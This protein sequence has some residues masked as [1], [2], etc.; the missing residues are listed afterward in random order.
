MQDDVLE[1][2]EDGSFDIAPS[3][4]VEQ[5]PIDTAPKDSP[6]SDDAQKDSEEDDS[7]PRKPKEHPRKMYSNF[8]IHPAPGNGGRTDKYVWAQTLSELTVTIPVPPGT[9]TKMLNV[10]ITNKRIKVGLKGSPPMV[11]GD[12]HKRIIVD[13]SLWTLE[14]GE[15]VL[16][17]QKENRMEWWKCVLSGMRVAS[18]L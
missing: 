1:A 13:D 15:I 3:R 9:K 4:P 5:K 10:E 18:T 8:T 12:L 17:L 6:V 7:P 2:G 14:D 16:S 11:E